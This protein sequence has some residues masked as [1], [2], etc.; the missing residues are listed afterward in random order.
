MAIVLT[1]SWY[2]NEF[3]PKLYIQCSFKKTLKRQPGT[4][5]S[6]L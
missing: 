5:V 2:L 1:G 6:H 3:V 4:V